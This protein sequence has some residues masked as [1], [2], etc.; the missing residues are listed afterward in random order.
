[1][2]SP[3][4]CGWCRPPRRVRDD[5][6]SWLYDPPMVEALDGAKGSVGEFLPLVR[7]DHHAL[8]R[9]HFVSSSKPVECL[10]AE[11]LEVLSD[12][13]LGGPAGYTSQ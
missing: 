5:R 7:C 10:W 4:C 6:T 9:L 13:E 3:S 2:A 11:G 8:V 12:S 1:M